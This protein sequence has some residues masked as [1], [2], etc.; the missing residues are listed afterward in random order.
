MPNTGAKRGA[1]PTVKSKAV[2][3]KGSKLSEAKQNLKR[4]RSLSLSP[5]KASTKTVS[6]EKKRKE[7]EKG[8]PHA[9]IVP[10][11][12]DVSASDGRAKVRHGSREARSRSKSEERNSQR[13][14][15]SRTPSAE[16][17]VGRHKVANVSPVRTRSRSRSATPAK[18]VQFSNNSQ[19][20]LILDYED[21][22]GDAAQTE[23]MDYTQNLNNSSTPSDDESGE[24]REDSVAATSGILGVC[25][26]PQPKMITMTEEQIQQLINK[27][28]DDF[29]RR[30]RSS[31]ERG[32]AR[33]DTPGTSSGPDKRGR[34][35]NIEERMRG[36][37]MGSNSESTVY[38]HFCDLPQGE[39]PH[40]ES[41]Q[42]A[43]QLRTDVGIAMEPITPGGPPVSDQSHESPMVSDDSMG[44]QFNSSDEINTSAFGVTDELTQAEKQRKVA[45][46]RAR[47]RAER[48]YQDA[49]I[50][51]V[52]LEVPPGECPHTGISIGAEPRGVP[53]TS[54]AGLEG[55]VDLARDNL[56]GSLDYLHEDMSAHV[57]AATRQLILNGDYVELH[58]LLPKDFEEANDEDGIEF[59]SRGGRT[60]FVPTG[61]KEGK[62][63][64][65][66]RKWEAAFR[67]FEEI[68]LSNHQNRARQLVRYRFL[69]E[70]MASTWVW[71]N[72]ARYERRHRYLM[73]SSKNRDWSVPYDKAKSELK[74]LH[75]MKVTKKLTAQTGTK[76]RREP[77]RNYN[78]GRCDYGKACKFDHKC[79]IC[80]KFGHGASVVVSCSV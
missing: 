58:R 26:A 57:D 43:Q 2:L 53:D 1:K 12:R 67:V 5:E 77:C 36:M 24:V 63:I 69:I 4:G 75:S 33:G 80:G 45:R 21:D 14:R 74:I 3:P 9:K 10:K 66:Y 52:Q 35:H 22:V 51:K 59:T 34:S 41:E 37:S 17:Q 32:G 28:L 44:A 78:R 31:G 76:A 79:S 40:S 42:R 62:T 48:M 49:D 8:K 18:T 56:D 71:E 19:D 11:G 72:V 20:D 29:E 61:D 47:D 7:T 39:G 46:D 23:E 38:N 70:D 64:S 30:R 60:F 25:V 6:Q 73:Q 15:K 54:N 55:K 13:S 27:S 68:Y 65:S 50:N 16:R